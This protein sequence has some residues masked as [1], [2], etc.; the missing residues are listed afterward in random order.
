MNFFT[1]EIKLI[2]K[3]KVDI[4]SDA[5]G[6]I[7][8]NKN[9]F[10]K[11]PIIGSIELGIRPEILVISKSGGKTIENSVRAQ[12]EEIS[13][14][15]DCT[16]YKIILASNNQTF[17]VSEMHAHRLKEWNVRDNV[18]VSWNPEWF[19]AFD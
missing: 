16:Q 12:I 6:K 17:L 14:Y 1:G 10:S 9:Q 7:S 3:S 2:S 8:I 15:G 19:V 4:E 11:E 13:F 5:L 18:Y